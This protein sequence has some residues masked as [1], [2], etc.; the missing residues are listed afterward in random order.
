MGALKKPGKRMSNTILC[1]D[2]SATMQKVAEITFSASDYQYVGARS[3]DEA[4]QKAKQNPPAIILA[5]AVMPGKSGYDLCKAVKADASLSKVIVLLVC[6]N[7]EAYDEAKGAQ[8]GADGHITKPWDTQKLLDKMG[9]VLSGK[10]ASASVGTAAAKPAPRAPTPVS[11]PLAAAGG[12]SAGIAK[13]LP[14]N[15]TMMGMPA[16]SLPVK[17]PTPNVTPVVPPGSG[18]AK[19]DAAVEATPANT[20]P[21]PENGSRAPMI[22]GTPS[23]SPVFRPRPVPPSVEEIARAAGFD[24]KGPEMAAIMNL[25]RA[26]V[27]RIVWEVVPDLAE[28]IIKENIDRIS[29]KVQ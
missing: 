7:S 19:F 17:K 20:S 25:S 29:P 23:E 26:V 18:S 2:D 3:A 21:A 24:P 6:G 14:N 10:P 16:A 1:A 13:P 4:L 27:E 28:T 12:G 5:D 9:E 15:A 11:A 22:S 8:A